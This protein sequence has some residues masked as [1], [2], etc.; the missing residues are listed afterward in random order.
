M[1]GKSAATLTFLLLTAGCAS[2]PVAPTATRALPPPLIGVTRAIPPSPQI[3]P[4]P[5]SFT[6]PPPLP[7]PQSDLARMADELFGERQIQSIAIPAL[8]VEAEVVPVGWRV[9]FAEDLQ[10]GAF[11]WD[12]PREKVGWAIDSA[13]PD[14]I[15]NVVLYGHN[16]L[17]ERI[18]ERLYQLQAGDFIYLRTRNQTYEYKARSVLRLPILGVDSQRLQE[19]RRYLQPSADSRLTLVSC[20]PPASNTHRVIVIAK[21]AK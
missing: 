19:Y 3:P 17:Y 5:A 4:A 6:P 13:L 7:I 16:N 8:G 9:N 10:S 15:G 20:Y 11:E 2:F 1:A 14:S 21:P 18:F 12:D